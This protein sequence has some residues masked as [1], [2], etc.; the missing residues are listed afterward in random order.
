MEK[1]LVI[2]AH[3]DDETLGLGATL[4][5]HSKKRDKIMVLVLATGQFARDDSVKGIAERK[6]QCR[7][8]CSIL[9][10]QKLKFFEYDDQHLEVIPITELSSRIENEING[11]K[12]TIIYTHFWGDHNQD[13]RRVFEAVLVATRPTSKFFVKKIICFE[14]PSST[15]WHTI[16]NN[17][18]P[19]M[20]VD[21]KQGI[22]KKI[23]ALL[24]YKDEVR[25]HPPTRSKKSLLARAQYWGSKIGVEFAE[26][27]IIL[28]EFRD[29]RD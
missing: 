3:P 6:D 22:N 18:E 7:K 27:F 5:L 8:A 19:N 21:S 28:R 26:P 29:W 20:F 25:R 16:K 17:F 11:W 10:V 2:C 1:I 24:Q 4:A 9:G 13:H 14:T 23:K 12:P 15:D